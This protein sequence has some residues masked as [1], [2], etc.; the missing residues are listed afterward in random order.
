M[1]GKGRTTC[2]FFQH[3]INRSL[4]RGRSVGGDGHGRAV[5]VLLL[6]L[7]VLEVLLLLLLLDAVKLLEDMGGGGGGGGRGPCQ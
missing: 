2:I 5:G 4:P 1:F 6:L 7:L 3:A